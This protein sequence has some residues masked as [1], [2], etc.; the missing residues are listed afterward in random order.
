MSIPVSAATTE[1]EIDRMTS[2]DAP[3]AAAPDRPERGGTRRRTALWLLAPGVGWMALFLALA[4]L[5][6]VCVSFWTETTFTIQPK[7]TLASWINFFSSDTYLTAL[8]TT[9]RIWLTVLAATLVA[10]Y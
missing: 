9:I 6:M 3:G 5:M 1:T 2:T 8:W 4:I 7:L 10:G